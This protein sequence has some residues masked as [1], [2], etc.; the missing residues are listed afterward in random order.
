MD[1]GVG[2]TYLEVDL[3]KIK[4]NLMKIKDHIGKDCEAMPVLKAN[5]A[6]M[7][8]EEMGL[9]IAGECG[10][11][12]IAVAQVFEAV[13]LREAG[14]DCKIL[15]M[16]G[17]P[18]DN[19]PA[20]VEYGI[21]MPVFNREFATLVDK[22]ANKQG[23]KSKLHIK[24]ETGMN[25]I[26]VKPGEDLDGLVD[27][28]KGLDGIE[29]T[30]IY[31]HL[32]ESQAVD[33]SFSYRQFDLFKGALAQLKGRGISPKYI[34]VC[35]SAATVW[36]NEAYFTHV[37]PGR[38]VYGMDPNADVNNR[39]GLEFP[40]TW[41]AFVTNLKEIEAG[42]TVGYNRYFKADRHMRVA[43]LSF[44]YGDGYNRN[45]VLKGGHVIINGKRAPFLDMCMDQ[46]FVD[47]TAIEDVKM[48]NRAVLLGR[49]GEEEISL[50]DFSKLLGE[51]YMNAMAT[52]GERVRRIYKGMGAHRC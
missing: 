12:T 17:V 40:V 22:E 8:L 44:G 19:V 5:A 32:V 14:V 52:I 10:V 50:L 38:L 20:A 31:T 1:L 13:R 41:H 48:N 33:K 51:G 9:F 39:W 30:G 36:F 27:C 46:S 34:H 35:N 4:A 6:G 18:Y 49:D 16:G 37:R 15:V 3:K 43:T 21:Q 47:V 42:E 7:G 45:L 25:R 23:K 28:L 2:N 11:K 24:I 26:G 29:I